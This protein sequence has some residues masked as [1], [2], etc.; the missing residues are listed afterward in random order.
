M[1]Y[2]S[3]VGLRQAIQAQCVADLTGWKRSIYPWDMF[4]AMG[5]PFEHKAFAVGIGTTN[6]YVSDDRQRRTYGTP[7]TSEITV[8]FTMRIRADNLVSDYD[9]ALTQEASVIEAA[10]G[11][12]NAGLMAIT[13]VSASREV[14]G[15]GTVYRG[16]TVFRC[17][18]RLQL[19]A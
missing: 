8:S 6:S 7:V 5:R 11:T 15:E 9:T 12:T 18:H 10:M 19:E 14:V 2:L 17:Y 1:G 3:A 4:P 13:F 16:D